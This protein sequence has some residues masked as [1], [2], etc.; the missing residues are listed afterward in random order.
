MVAGLGTG[1]DHDYSPP[2]GAR[3]A[4]ASEA[5]AMEAA[6]PGYAEQKE[7]ANT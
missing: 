6:E 7:E 3:L 1:G 4:R 5:A 2:T